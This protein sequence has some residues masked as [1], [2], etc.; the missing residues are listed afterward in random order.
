MDFAVDRQNAQGPFL[1]HGGDSLRS[2]ARE[3]RIA[4]GM[5][6][7]QASR[8]PRPSLPG[9]AACS[10]KSQRIQCP[11]SYLQCHTS[12][13]PDGSLSVRLK[14]TT[15][16]LYET[17][18]RFASVAGGIKDE[19]IAN[20]WRETR[21]LAPSQ[22]L[23]V[24]VEVLTDDEPYLWFDYMRFLNNC[25]NQLELATD[26][27]FLH[28]REGVFRKKSKQLC[29]YEV[30]DEV[31]WEAVDIE[32]RGL[33]KERAALFGVSINL[34]EITGQHGGELKEDSFAMSSGRLHKVVV[35][36]DPKL[37]GN[38]EPVAYKEGQSEP[39][40]DQV[41]S[42]AVSVNTELDL[43]AQGSKL[44]GPLLR[45]GKTLDEAAEYVRTWLNA[46]VQRKSIALY[47]RVTAEGNGF[48]IEAY[49]N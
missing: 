11:S 40:P 30:A 22:L 26:L 4:L 20:Q 10:R 23:Q 44:V 43:C 47:F 8:E 27:W 16:G 36:A 6:L 15:E 45:A 39:L 9:Q 49:G 1:R 48:S 38:K 42:H 21:K 5:P 46:E 7:H 2:V 13:E 31:M 29:M 18:K 14:T 28:L 12:W 37:D 34:R 35:P 25:M 33:E 24:T 32:T 19:K 41:G 17:L 3:Y